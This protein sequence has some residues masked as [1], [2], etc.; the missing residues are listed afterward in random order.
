[1]AMFLR[2]KRAKLCVFLTCEA[3]DKGSDMLRKL[4]SLLGASY[5]AGKARLMVSS[6][7]GYKVI[8]DEK[9]VADMGIQNDQV[10]YIVLK[11][12]DDSWEEPHV[13]GPSAPEVVDAAAPPA[14]SS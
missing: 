8:P 12:E 4:E 7:E 6:E 1:M 2:L 14:S 5:G 9:S 10:V 3:T 13:D 11:R